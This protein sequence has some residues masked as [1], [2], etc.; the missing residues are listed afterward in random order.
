MIMAL[1][2]KP[3]SG[4]SFVFVNEMDDTVGEIFNVGETVVFPLA[5]SISVGVGVNNMD[6]GVVVVG[7][8]RPVGV[9][10]DILVGVSDD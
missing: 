2:I 4:S 3:D 6:V 5:R 9:N 1:L 8:K 7:C 10:W